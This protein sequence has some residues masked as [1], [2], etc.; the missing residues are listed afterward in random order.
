[1]SLTHWAS[2]SNTLLNV[3]FIFAYFSCYPGVLNDKANIIDHHTTFCFPFVF[4]WYCLFSERCCVK[5]RYRLCIVSALVCPLW[6]FYF[7]LKEALSVWACM[8]V[9]LDLFLTFTSHY[10][11]SKFFRFATLQS[12]CPTFSAC[13]SEQFLSSNFVSLRV[14]FAFSTQ[15]MEKTAT[16]PQKHVTLNLA[17]H[18]SWPQRINTQCLSSWNR[19]E[20]Q[21]LRRNECLTAVSQWTQECQIYLHTRVEVFCGDY[22]QHQTWRFLVNAL[23]S[24]TRY[25]TQCNCI[26]IW[27]CPSASSIK[28]PVLM[29][30][31]QS[32]LCCTK[33]TQIIQTI[34]QHQLS[35]AH[36]PSKL[37]SFHAIAFICCQWS[38]LP[39]LTSQISSL[40]TF[41]HINI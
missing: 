34:S 21:P 16:L 14:C 29:N 3:S 5:L 37:Q 18:S 41:V 32:A 12:I 25:I 19:A 13:V 10:V 15:N 9:F 7:V 22:S 38:R 2:S 1:M 23:S 40:T 27:P 28:P 30:L 4:V 31:F 35:S 11:L 33:I 6:Q 8:L 39:Y 24:K 36:L 26:F 17:S 20:C